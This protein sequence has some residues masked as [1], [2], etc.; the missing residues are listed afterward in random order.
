A[1][2]QTTL[3]ND[4]NIVIPSLRIAIRKFAE[5]SL[6]AERGKLQELLDGLNAD[7]VGQ[8]LSAA[9]KKIEKAAG[10]VSAN[11]VDFTRARLEREAAKRRDADKKE[12]KTSDP[13]IL[14]GGSGKGSNAPSQSDGNPKVAALPEASTF[15]L[16][17]VSDTPLGKVTK[18]IKEAEKI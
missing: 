8:R 17:Y 10:G 11:D 18:P 6:K 14:V 12:G 3:R 2:Y 9:A 5:D 15:W 4:Y 7:G 16:N 13:P 1:W